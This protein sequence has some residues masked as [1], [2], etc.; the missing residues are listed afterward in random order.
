MSADTSSA[1]RSR[2]HPLCLG[3]N[4]FGWTVGP[5]DAAAVLDAYADRGGTFI[6]TADQYVDWMPGGAGGESETMIGDW[7]AR[8]GN[9]AEMVVATKVGKG[10]AAKGL[11]RSAIRTSVDES[12]RRLRTDYVDIYYAH[13]DDPGTPLEETLQVFDELV[14]EG[15][16][17]ALGASN[18]SAQRLGDALAVSDAA[19]WERFRF[20]QPHYNLAER[21]RYEGPLAELCLR[22]VITCVPY[23]SLAMGFLTG[24]YRPGVPVSSQRA[25]MAGKYLDDRG[26]GLLEALDETAAGHGVSV[27][28]VSLAWLVRQPTVGSALASARTPEQVEDLMTMVSVELTDEDLRRLDAASGPPV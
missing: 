27:S 7:M 25:R 11:S 19:G 1:L 24:K 22:E 12:L 9:R 14:R 10:P 23:F 20:L 17:L 18:Y 26:I 16:V 13:E 6:D 2:L 15:K 21:S 3:G 4:V 28:A 8:R 5:D